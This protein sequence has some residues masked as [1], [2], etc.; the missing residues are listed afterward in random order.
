M[1]IHHIIQAPNN[2]VGAAQQER[3][4]SC[5]VTSGTNKTLR[6]ALEQLRQSD[7]CLFSGKQTHS[8]M[9]VGSKG[10]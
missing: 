2:Y 1:L 7:V 8:R 3:K 10:V 9:T 5:L 6:R 4:C